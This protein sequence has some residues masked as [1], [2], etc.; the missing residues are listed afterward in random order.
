MALIDAGI[1]VGVHAVLRPRYVG[2]FL[3]AQPRVPRRRPAPAVAQRAREARER[4]Q[5]VAVA[6]D[7]QCSRAAP[8]AR[9]VRTLP[10]G[11]HHGPVSEV[12]LVIP[13]EDGGAVWARE[14]RHA[15]VQ[16][17]SRIAI[18]EPRGEALALLALTLGEP[19]RQHAVLEAGRQVEQSRGIG[20]ERPIA[21]D[22][23]ARAARD[24]GERARDGGRSEQA[25]SA[26]QGGAEE[27]A[28]GPSHV[29]RSLTGVLTRRK[30]DAPGL[31]WRGGTGRAAPLSA[32]C[33]RCRA[34]SVARPEC[35]G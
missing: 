6:I 9:V 35:A 14:R 10:A 12:Q 25:R 7:P 23:G 22:D 11:V 20:L 13:H 3:G 29:P 28:T 4:L 5:Q 1:E 21:L 27:A 2:G 16:P 19:G 8:G 15:V 33:G 17:G 26:E 34:S 18:G 31:T 32:A 30:R 24:G